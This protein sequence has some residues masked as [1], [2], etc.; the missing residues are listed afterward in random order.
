MPLQFE[1]RKVALKQDRTGYV[2]TL[3]LHPDEIPEELL[4]DFV[5]ARYGC[6]LVRI[7]DDESATPYT[8]RVS[9][10]GMLCRL[11]RFQDFLE[12]NSEDKAA[13]VLCKRLGI[14]SRTELHGNHMAQIAFDDLVK[15]YKNWSID[16]DPF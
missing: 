1:A 12:V 6:A 5:G 8:N 3:S 2:L 13:S 14:A 10:A 9:Q 16:D 4:R 15:E 7:Q 11:P